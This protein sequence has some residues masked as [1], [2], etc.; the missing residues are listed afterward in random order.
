MNEI[1]LSP[2]MA[3]ALRDSS[4]SSRG[5]VLCVKSTEDALLRQGLIA[6]VSD[7]RCRHL[8]IITVAGW[9]WLKET[10]G[11]ERPADVGRMTQAQAL[12]DYY[13]I[14]R[15]A[16]AGRLS[17]ADALE[18][19]ASARSKKIN[20]M[21][22]AMCPCMDEAQEAH[23]PHDSGMDLALEEAYTPGGQATCKHGRGLDDT[24]DDCS[25]TR[26]DTHGVYMGVPIPE[27]L[28][29]YW[30][31]PVAQGWRMGVEATRAQ[32]R[33]YAELQVPRTASAGKAYEAEVLRLSAAAM[34]DPAYECWSCHWKFT[35]RTNLENHLKG[36]LK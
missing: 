30:G 1:K 16:D 22:H 15:P 32:V 33:Q 36:H 7:P 14:D 13:G 21:M 24:C 23:V 6:H 11:I 4:G 19:A 34:G 9:G 28:L 25:E 20:P 31:S 3:E 29:S 26:G 12:L 5:S 8:P 18:A 27:S 10:H 17:L 2:K 35:S